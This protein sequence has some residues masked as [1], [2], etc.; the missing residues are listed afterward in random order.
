MEDNSLSLV[1]AKKKGVG[2]GEQPKH[3]SVAEWIN[4]HVV[5]LP[6]NYTAASEKK[7]DYIENT[8]KI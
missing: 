4:T 8:D 6:M 2:T 7:D 1:I 3:P 5:F